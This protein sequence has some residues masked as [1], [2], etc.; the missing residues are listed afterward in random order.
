MISTATFQLRFPDFKKVSPT[1]IEDTLARAQRQIDACVWGTLND[2]G[3]AL[4]A[5]DLLAQLPG[6]NTTKMEPQEKTIYRLQYEE[7]RRIVVGAFP[8]GGT[9][10]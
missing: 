7:L 6:T 3:V 4:L 8:G 9:W 5:A 1:L 2:D 10:V